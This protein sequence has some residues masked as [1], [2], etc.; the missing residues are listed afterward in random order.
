MEIGSIDPDYG[1]TEPDRP[2]FDYFHFVSSG[3]IGQHGPPEHDRAGQNTG[4]DRR[5]K[6]MPVMRVFLS[7]QPDPKHEIATV[8]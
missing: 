1:R 4:N 6:N 8:L 7:S 3:V 5:R 2:D